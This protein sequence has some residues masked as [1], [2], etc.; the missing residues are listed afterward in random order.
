[1]IISESTIQLYS[2][3]TA[4][5]RTESRQSLTVWQGEE[6]PK[7]SRSGHNKRAA[8][9]NAEK[10]IRRHRDSVSLAHHHGVRR[11]HFRPAEMAIPEEQQLETDLNV[12]LIRSLFERLTGRTFQLIDPTALTADHETASEP[13]S[14]NEEV[15]SVEASNSDE[16]GL[17]YDY[18]QSHY[19]YEK[20]EVAAGG[21]I[22]TADGKEIDFSISLSMSRE[23]YTEQNMDLRT[24]EVLKD[25]LVVNFSG[26]AAEL[27]QREFQFDIDADGHQDQVSFVGPGSGFLALDKNGDNTIN[28]GTE[29][30]GAI[31]GNGFQE[32]ATYDSDSN[33]WIDENDDIFDSLRIWT[34]NSDGEDQLIGLGKAGVGALYLGH[35]ESLFSIKDDDNALLGQVRDTGLAV[36]ETGEVVTMQQLDLVA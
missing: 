31:S 18:H 23:F 8:L 6:G 34:K 33:N 36:M 29:L 2:E 32:L 13:V 25:P 1:M 5:E 27:S 4:T 35:I 19:E 12:N 11:R 16:Y 24:K 22:T 7:V 28:D 10:R 20:T 3:R 21:V 26:T 9:E 14:Q 30:F 15:V 17:S